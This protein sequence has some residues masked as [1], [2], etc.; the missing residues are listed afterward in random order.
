MFDP[1]RP[2][3]YRLAVSCTPVTE[4]MARLLA[5]LSDWPAIDLEELRVQPE[6]DQ[7][8]AWGWMMESGELTGSGI[9]HVK[10]LPHCLVPPVTR[11][12]GESASCGS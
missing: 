5:A 7:A 4:A 9:A 1:V 11:N 6:W 10:E 2:G 8:R 12:G 3:P